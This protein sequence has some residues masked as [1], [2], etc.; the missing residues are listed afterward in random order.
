VTLLELRS[1]VKHYRVGTGELVRAVDGVS[2]KVEAGAFAALFGPSGS[3]KT[4]LLEVIAGL[5]RADRGSVLV[6]GQDIGLLSET[7]RDHYRLRD[8]GMIGGPESLI[9]GARAIENAVLKLLLTNVRGARSEVEPLLDE[10]GLSGRL[11]HRTDQLSMGER[12][13]LLIAR[14]LAIEPKLVLADEP[15]GSLD[16]QRTREV[17]GI[18]RR[19]CRERGAAVLLATHDPLALGFADE[20]YELRDGRLRAYAQ[21]DSRVVTHVPPG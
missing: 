5:K 17:L 4:T 14:A 1:L 18:L 3:G 16:T 21:E 10:L 2:M 15:T 11:E 19:V 12:Q 9:P 6:D 13:R 7:Q 8:L 20:V